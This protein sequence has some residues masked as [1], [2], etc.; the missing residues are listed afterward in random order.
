MYLSFDEGFVPG[1]HTLKLKCYFFRI[2]TRAVS[3]TVCS[4][5]VGL[6]VIFLATIAR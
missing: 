5:V 6:F 1:H 2:F 3:R 4:S